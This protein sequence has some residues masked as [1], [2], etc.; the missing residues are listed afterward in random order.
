MINSISNSRSFLSSF[1]LIL[2]AVF[3]LYFGLIKPWN[4]VGTDFTNYW[5][6]S[7]LLLSG[8]DLVNHYN[9]DWVAE[10]AKLY[11][12][13]HTVVL[14]QFTPITAF[15]FVPISI[16]DVETA[17]RIYLL[18]N[19]I[20]LTLNIFLLKQLT[21]FDLKNI[22]ILVLLSGFCLVNN[23]AFG[24]FYN[25]LLLM[26]LCSIYLFKKGEKI[27]PGILLGM[28]TSVKYFPVIFILIFLFQ[29][30]FKLVFT[31]FFTIFLLT[32]IEVITM[33]FDGYLT[34][35]F[36]VFLPHLSGNLTLASTHA[37]AFQSWDSLLL[38]LFQFDPVYN[39]NPIDDN[40]LFYIS[41]KVFVYLFSFITAGISIAKLRHSNQKSIDLY[42][43]L[44]SILA[45]MLL[46][47]SGTYHF[48][49]LIFPVCLF[50]KNIDFHRYK[51]EVILFL[52][53]YGII[54]FFPINKIADLHLSGWKVL[55]AYPR[56]YAVTIMY[57]I[58]YRTVNHLA[59]KKDS[60][61]SA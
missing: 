18:I 9:N 21:E 1:F 38:N 42:M 15:L 14:S 31:S 10:K 58:C 16:F 39:Q 23:F 45:L 35:I 5:L 44:I 26:I 41:A 51:M 61:Y 50:L 53:C 43:I 29:K 4:H 6:D 46:P 25:L 8:S 52:I 60:V 40:R 2:L 59:M 12:F 36:S 57:F 33:G 56:L 30:E 19:V 11:G 13:N 24:Q 49:L 34:F 20:F 7:K 3:F 27:V 32:M 17:F 55:F 37:V 28:G 47:A 22:S 48:I 54:G